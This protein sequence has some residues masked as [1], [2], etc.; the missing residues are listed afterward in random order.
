MLARRLTTVLPAMTL[1][2]SIETARIPRVDGLESSGDPLT[3][4]RSDITTVA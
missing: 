1:A 3:D 2:E 4:V